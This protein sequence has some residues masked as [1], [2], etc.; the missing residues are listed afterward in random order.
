MSDAVTSPT[1]SRFMSNTTTIVTGYVSNNKISSSALP[2]VIQAVHKTLK[3]LAEG[4]R[5]V[6]P[7]MPA[8]SPKKSVFPDY[9]ICLE[10]GKH[11]AMLKRHLMDAFKMTPDQYRTKWGL[12]YTY[13]MVAPNYSKKR[14]E[15]ALSM[16]L[17][18]RTLAREGQ[19][20]NVAA[21]KLKRVAGSAS[22]SR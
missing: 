8:V 12:P 17:G 2:E 14:R 13:P 18:T 15:L 9:L 22:A 4:E 19:H 6:E 5:P 1:Q 16:G 3:M 21:S 10:D 7:P 20:H 11:L